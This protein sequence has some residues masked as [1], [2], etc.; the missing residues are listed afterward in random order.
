MN[1]NDSFR[2]SPP[3][4]FRK[5]NKYIHPQS[6]TNFTHMRPK[7]NVCKS[8]PELLPSKNSPKFNSSRSNFTFVIVI[9]RHVW[10]HKAKRVLRLILRVPLSSPGPVQIPED[11]KSRR[12]HVTNTCTEFLRSHPIL[13]EGISRFVYM[14]CR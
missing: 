7:L 9:D 3:I 11:L 4:Y 13:S 14:R 2:K 12:T 5:Q 6:I 8:T 10:L 1:S